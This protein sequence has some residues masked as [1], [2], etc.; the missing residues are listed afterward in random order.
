MSLSFTTKT[1]CKK[2][3]YAYGREYKTYL[4]LHLSCRETWLQQIR[5]WHF[6]FSSVG[7]FCHLFPFCILTF[8]Q[9]F[10][11]HVHTHS[12]EVDGA[13]PL[14]VLIHILTL[15]YWRQLPRLSIGSY[16]NR[17]SITAKYTHSNSNLSSFTHI[18]Q[19]FTQC[20]LYR[21]IVIFNIPQEI[22]F[23]RGRSEWIEEWVAVSK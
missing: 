13:D 19:W 17:P 3:L 21:K 22:S 12:L 2:C 5:I 23:I 20:P 14:C 1:F 7:C 6:N 9:S 8:C 15:L 16:Y 11:T 4:W 10:V 18:T